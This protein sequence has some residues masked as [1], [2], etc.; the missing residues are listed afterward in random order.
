MND[1]VFILCK[2]T[3]GVQNQSITFAP[4]PGWPF[5]QARNGFGQ[6]T[7]RPQEALPYPQAKSVFL[8]SGERCDLRTGTRLLTLWNRRK[9]PKAND[10]S[11]LRNSAALGIA[12]RQ[13]R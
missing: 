12:D 4:V 5:A 6:Q 9:S 10:A 1:V 2:I 3:E 11:A 8:I 13:D 7:R